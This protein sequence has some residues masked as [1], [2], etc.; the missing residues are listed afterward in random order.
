[1]APDSQ[2]N[3]PMGQ[4]GGAAPELADL[5]AIWSGL[6]LTQIPEA[7]AALLGVVGALAF[8]RRRR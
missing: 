3:V 2:V 5:N 6:A 7:S 1:M 8:W 4:L